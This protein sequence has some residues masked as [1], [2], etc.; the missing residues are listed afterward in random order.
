MV[1]IAGHSRVDRATT[2]SIREIGE[3]ASLDSDIIKLKHGQD[4]AE[5]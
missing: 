5:I 4:R 1:C 3:Q 2:Y